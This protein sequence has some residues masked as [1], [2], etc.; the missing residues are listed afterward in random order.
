MNR[1]LVDYAQ[2]TKAGE[3]Y[4]CPALDNN[5]NF[6][7]FSFVSVTVGAPVLQNAGLWVARWRSAPM[8][9]GPISVHIQPGFKP[10]S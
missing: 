3:H 9:R 5:G 1:L 6:F 8:L 2:Q 10:V 4:R 7:F